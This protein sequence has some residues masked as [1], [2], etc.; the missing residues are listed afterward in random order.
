MKYCGEVGFL[1]TVET[2][3]GIWEEVITTRVYRGDIT[4]CSRRIVAAESQINDNIQISN[5]I[6]II[7]D[8][9]ALDNFF[10]IKYVTYMGSKWKVNNVEVQ[11]PRLILHIGDLYNSEEADDQNGQ[12]T[13]TTCQVRGITWQ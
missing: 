2:S 10:K 11:H 9:Y 3:P 5:D 4:R 13:N 12:Q 6:S 8:M 1:D 7:S